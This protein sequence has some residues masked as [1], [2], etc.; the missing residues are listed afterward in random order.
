M[1]KIKIIKMV[2]V[3]ALLGLTVAMVNAAVMPGRNGIKG[4]VHQ[5]DAR[6]ALAQRVH[7][8]GNIWMAISNYGNYGD[9]NASL[10]SAEWP[11]G[12]EVYYIWEGR[13]WL[14]AMVGANHL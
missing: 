5:T 9:P 7:D 1:K 2:A 10:P 13:F 11:S 4:P 12:S 14:G 8:V 3:L 6:P